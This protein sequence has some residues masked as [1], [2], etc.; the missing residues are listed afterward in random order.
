MQLVEKAIEESLAI[1]EA[2]GQELERLLANKQLNGRMIAV[3]GPP[4][5]GKSFLLRKC[6]EL[7]PKDDEGR[8]I[9]TCAARTHVASRQF[10][11]GVTLSRLK[12]AIQKGRRPNGVFCLDELFMTE[13]ALLDVVVAWRHERLLHQSI[14]ADP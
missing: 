12:H 13:V 14:S 2:S 1:Q 10:D 3:L 5:T 6:L 11:T 8:P 9:V 4:G 7:L